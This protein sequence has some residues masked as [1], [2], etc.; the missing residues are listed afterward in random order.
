[1]WFTQRFTAL[2][3]PTDRASVGPQNASEYQEQGGFARTSRAVKRH[4]LSRE[5]VEAGAG[6][7]AHAGRTS[8]HSCFKGLDYFPGAQ[9]TRD[10]HA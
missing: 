6:K 1:V 10:V 9:C 5:E 7:R 8:L 2:R 3:N 4:V